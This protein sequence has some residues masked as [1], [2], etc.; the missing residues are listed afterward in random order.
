MEELRYTSK[1]KRPTRLS[2]FA[3]SVF[4]LC[5]AYQPVPA[6][7]GSK[8]Q[9]SQKNDLAAM[10]QEAEQ[11]DAN[12]Q[13]NLGMRYDLGLG[14]PQSYAQAAGWYRKAAALGNIKAQFALGVDF[15]FGIGVTRDSVQAARWYR[16]AA[17]RGDAKAQSVL[18]WLYQKGTGVPQ[19]SAQAALWYRKAAE[20]G[21]AKAQ[22]N[23]GL[24]YALGRGVQQDYAEAYFWIGVAAKDKVEGTTQEDIGKARDAAASYLTAEQ[25]SQAQARMRNWLETHPAEEIPH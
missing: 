13:F 25:H 5:Y 11:G 23:L 16:E 12:A 19:D 24:L 22:Y 20:Q 8:T 4:L 3:F 17:M 9:A 14:V 2:V 10:Q 21:D 15:T 7:A 18:G 1:V 6:Q